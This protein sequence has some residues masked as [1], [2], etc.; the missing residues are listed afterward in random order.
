M[1]RQEELEIFFRIQKE[2]WKEDAH[3]Q[4]ETY[5]EW[6]EDERLEN[7]DLDTIDWDY[8]VAEFEDKQDCD[9]AENDT[10]YNIVNDYFKN[11]YFDERNE[12]ND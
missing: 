6:A 11:I 12:N 2:F 9:V 3:Y 1:T 8:L 10:W 7:I 4:V 5:L